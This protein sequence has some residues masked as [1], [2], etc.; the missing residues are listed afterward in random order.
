MEQYLRELKGLKYI[1]IRN[2]N[3]KFIC[4][5]PISEFK[6]DGRINN[7]LL[8]EFLH[9]L[10]QSNIVH[11]YGSS[12]ITEHVDEN[13]SLVESL[14]IMRKKNIHQLVVLD[15]ND[16]FIGVLLSR[17]V[18]KRIAEDVLAAKENA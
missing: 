10:S 16:N 11:I 3:G 7:N 15:E 5:V 1:E 12:L 4:L 8:G 9:E 2:K 13:A 14:K 6:P 18:E 17:T